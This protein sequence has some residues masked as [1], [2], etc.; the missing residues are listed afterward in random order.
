M[1]SLKTTETLRLGV[2]SLLL[3]PA[4]SILTMLGILFG[5]CAVIATLSVVEGISRKMQEEVLKMGATNIIVQAVRPAESQSTT[6]GSGSGGAAIMYGLTYEDAE[7]I[8]SSVAGADVIVPARRIRTTAR[9]FTRR[10]RVEILGTVP[11]YADTYR[12]EVERGRWLT[13]LDLHKTDNVCVLGAAV[14]RDLMPR[15][16]PVGQTLWLGE[17]AYRVVGVLGARGMSGAS[18]GLGGKTEDF[19]RVIYVPLTAA[20]RR[21]GEVLVD[22]AAGMN[23]FEVCELHEIT[24][25]VAEAEQVRPAA[26]IITH[27]LEKFH[28]TARPDW[29][30]R[31]PLERLEALERTKW[32]FVVLGA[33]IAAISLLVGGIGIMNIMLASVTERTRE[34]GIRRAMGAKRKDIVQQFLVE[35]VVLSTLG[36]AVGVPVGA[37]LATLI[38]WGLTKAAATLGVGGEAALAGLAQ[39][40]VT[41][42]AVIL[43][44][45]TSVFVGV[46][47]GVYPAYRAS[48]MDPIRALRHE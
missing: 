9:Y 6:A 43:A 39:T 20:S 31:V 27:L 36:G 10:T 48:M 17:Y 35:T 18:G 42:G 4:R 5:V 40:V 44:L 2:E 8:Q 24:V 7:R 25:K 3:H 13:P 11:W 21:F 41:P 19:D 45:G 14:A 37:G 23:S 16:E 33:S 12:I 29:A 28:D 34:I 26:R 46:A 38:P 1:L 32:L 47:S 30:V 22:R 15:M